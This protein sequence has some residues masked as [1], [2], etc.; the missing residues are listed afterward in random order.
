MPDYSTFYTA[1]TI[2]INQISLLVIDIRKQ[3]SKHHVMILYTNHS[4]VRTINEK[5]FLNQSDKH[6][7][8]NKA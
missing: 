8:I 2:M 4:T 1:T 7:A 5:C 6:L 3:K